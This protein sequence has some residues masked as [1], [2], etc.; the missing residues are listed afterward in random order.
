M[1]A[2]GRSGKN[3]LDGGL[4]QRA[5]GNAEQR[6]GQAELQEEHA[7]VDGQRLEDRLVFALKVGPRR[8][9]EQEEHFQQRQCCGDDPA[10]GNGGKM[11]HEGVYGNCDRNGDCG[12]DDDG[13]LLVAGERGAPLKNKQ[14]GPDAC[15]D[16]RKNMDG[17]AC[18]S[19]N[20]RNKQQR[21]EC[22]RD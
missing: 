8:L 2:A 7:T 1:L 21:A 22:H 6:D 3:G 5:D 10:Q 17:D 12:V 4:P 14:G 15:N 18:L 11:E 20:D 16:A 9:F 13:W 19:V